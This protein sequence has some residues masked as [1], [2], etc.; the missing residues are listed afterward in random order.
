MVAHAKLSASG[1][2]RWLRCPGSV[3]AEEGI[4]ERLSS[5]AAEGT[6]AH[7]LAELCLISE[8]SATSYL[9]ST[10]KESGWVVTEEMTMYVQEYVDYVGSV[11]G[12]KYIEQQVDFSE[13]VPDGFGTSD[14]IVIDQ[15][16]NT[17]HIIDLK[18]GKGIRVDADNNS[19]AKLYALGALSDFGF[20]YNIDRIVCHIHQP[21]L[22]H[23]S[24]WEVRKDHLLSWAEYVR[25]RAGLCELP[26]APRVVGEKQCTWCKAKATCKELM[27]LTESALM[28]DFDDVTIA[29]KSPDKLSIRDLRFALDNKKLIISWLDAIEDLAFERLTNGDA[30]DG[31]KLVVGRSSRSWGDEK[32]AEQMLSEELGDKAYA[33]QKMITPP[34]A[35][36]LLGKK[37]A[38]LLD[39][40]ITKS[41]GK[42][43]MV[44][45]NDTRPEITSGDISDFD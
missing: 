27:R 4:V 5:F 31:Y 24:V 14:A 17:M 42:P 40:L 38:A 39:G 28:A 22:D 6:A 10:L 15:D 11:I 9:H 19:Q 23:V 45:H 8:R 20:F 43:T 32:A 35:E 7:E 25:E 21:R 18:Y 44:N 34:V 16:T 30:F 29:P 1:S 37:K 36:K 2:E 13:W 41:Q 3:R 12:T 26:D 33:P